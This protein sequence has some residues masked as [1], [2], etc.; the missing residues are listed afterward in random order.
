MQAGTPRAGTRPAPQQLPL[1]DGGGRDSRVRGPQPQLHQ[2]AGVHKQSDCQLGEKA[3]SVPSP[4]P[5]PAPPPCP[6]VP[7]PW[8][9]TGRSSSSPTSWGEAT[10]GLRVPGGRVPTRHGVYCPRRPAPHLH[11]ILSCPPGH[12]WRAPWRQVWLQA[13][14]SAG[15]TGTEPSSWRSEGKQ[16]LQTPLHHWRRTQAKGQVTLH[17]QAQ[18]ASHPPSRAS[19]PSAGPVTQYRTGAL[20]SDLVSAAA[21]ASESGGTGAD[22]PREPRALFTH[23][24]MGSES[25][26]EQGT[27]QTQTPRMS[28]APPE[29]A[30]PP[31]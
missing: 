12:T 21:P 8:L 2:Q 30:C 9:G 3:G 26:S 13:G 5:V 15:L 19:G 25:H 27:S 14:G 20:H 24:L 23:H 18:G 17:V 10:R 28:Q 11:P 6:C 29:V 16:G 1:K 7:G 22:T 4:R 31:A